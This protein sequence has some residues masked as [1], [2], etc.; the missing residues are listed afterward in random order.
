M[1]AMPYTANRVATCEWYLSRNPNPRIWLNR[2][3]A[4]APARARGMMVN[5]RIR[6]SHD[7]RAHIAI[8]RTNRVMAAKTQKAMRVECTTDSDGDG[9]MSDPISPGLSLSWTFEVSMI[10]NDLKETPLTES[11]DGS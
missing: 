6:P 3:V 10:A 9:A 4:M 5:M 8:M 7:L 2:Y 1:L 11:K